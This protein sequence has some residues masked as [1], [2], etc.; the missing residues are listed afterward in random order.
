M[1]GE[2]GSALRDGPMY[3]ELLPDVL[4]DR[5][6]DRQESLTQQHV[7]GVPVLNVLARKIEESMAEAE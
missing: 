3:P 5:G 6:L 7:G 1:D 4:D 2:E